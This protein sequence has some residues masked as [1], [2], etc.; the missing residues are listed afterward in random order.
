M[1]SAAGHSWCRTVN[2]IDATGASVFVDKQCVAEE[3]C[4][5]A[6]VGCHDSNDAPGSRDCVT[7][8]NEDYCNE[9]AP[10]NHSAA[11]DLSYPYFAP[12]SS[13]TSFGVTNSLLIVCF[14]SGLIRELAR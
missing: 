11:L 9:L 1:V 10:T 7:C 13:A 5:L 2:R 3:H 12:A 8:C 6:D 4:R 14:I